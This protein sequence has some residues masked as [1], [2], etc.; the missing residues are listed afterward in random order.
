MLRALI[1][2]GSTANVVH[3]HTWK[4]LKQHKIVAVLKH[5]NKRLYPYGSRNPLSIIGKFTSS[6]EV[7]KQETEAEFLI[8]PGQ[9]HTIL[10]KETAEKLGVLRI[11]PKVYTMAE[12]L[13]AKDTQ[14]QYPSVCNGI[15]KIK[16]YQAEI[17]IDPNVT[18]AAQHMHRIPL[19]MHEKQ[20]A[21]IH[22]LLRMT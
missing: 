3:R 22:E 10:S 20:E 12:K 18:P 15:G 1:N 17:N 19:V 2:S 8:I 6:T 13:T 16:N 21:K 5:T 14:K 7:G 11:G 9:G 4:Y